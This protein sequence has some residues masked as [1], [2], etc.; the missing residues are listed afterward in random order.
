ME[1]APPFTQRQEA[2]GNRYV[3]E[4]SLWGTGRKRCLRTAFRHR[5]ASRSRFVTK[6]G[7]DAGNM[8]THFRFYDLTM[9]MATLISATR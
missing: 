4:K 2:A 5:A 1:Q 9:T 6:P 8:M 3:L 7:R